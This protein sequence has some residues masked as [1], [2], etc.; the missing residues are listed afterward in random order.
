MANQSYKTPF[1]ALLVAGA[2]LTAC[3]GATP[4]PAG[5]PTPAPGGVTAIPANETPAAT[6]P[7]SAETSPTPPAVSDA[8]VDAGTSATNTVPTPDAAQQPPPG[9]AASNGALP[10]SININAAA[11]ADRVRADTMAARMS[12]VNTPDFS[13]GLPNHVRIAFDD[14]T[15]T[16]DY[17]D[18]QQRQIL[19]IPIKDYLAHFE[20]TP[21]TQQFVKKEIETL[22]AIL[23]KR[24]TRVTGDIPVFPP[25]NAAQV[26]HARVK[27][28]T[29]EGGSGVRFITTYAQDTVP[30]TS[31]ELFYTFQGLTNDGKYL[32]S[33]FF[34]ARVEGLAPTRSK[35]TQAELDQI[36]KNY[37]AYLK[38]RVALIEKPLPTDFEPSLTDLDTVLA[39]LGLQT[40]A[41][42]EAQAQAPTAAPDQ[43]ATPDP[44]ADPKANPNQVATSTPAQTNNATVDSA[45]AQTGRAT[46]V[47]NVRASPSTRGRIL[48]RLRRGSAVPV[49]GRNE[50]GDWVKV[51]I[52][53]RQGWVFARYLSGI[54]VKTL[55]I[56]R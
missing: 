51:T 28:F 50:A 29:F 31:D 21:D 26:L 37:D 1:V 56:V 3:R 5:I 17:V 45:K 53:R 2:L 11:I 32:I 16:N 23:R 48:S 19:I 7:P 52:A 22:R 9:A 30:I 27:Y 20:S 36:T 13:S 41:A 6:P 35:V 40:N 24:S 44:K 8:P 34:P 18:F 43:A 47:L 14:D 10:S 12:E 46:D 33:A 25:P 15:I 42:P 38:T 55:P 54:D 4:K 49:I 39:T